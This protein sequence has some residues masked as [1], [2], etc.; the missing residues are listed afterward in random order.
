MPTPLDELPEWASHLFDDALDQ[1]RAR[2]RREKEIDDGSSLAA[3]DAALPGASG[4][5]WVALCSGVNH[6]TALRSLWLTTKRLH[7]FADPTLLRAALLAA[8][9]AV[10]YLDASAGVDRRERL[11]RLAL[12]KLA[13]AHDRLTAAKLT[14]DWAIASGDDAADELRYRDAVQTEYD[15]AAGV[16]KA[17]GATRAQRGGPL[18]ANL[19]VKV[20]AEATAS[21]YPP[22]MRQAVSIAYRLAWQMG[23][24]DAHS[25]LWQVLA[26]LAQTN[27]P[28]R[29]PI[30][31]DL[32][33]SLNI[34]FAAA[35]VLNHGWWLWQLRSRN[36]AALLARDVEPPPLIAGALRHV[37]SP[38]RSASSALGLVR[39]VGGERGEQG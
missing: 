12:G 7:V 18:P 9:T 21:K 6:L 16:A 1:W 34:L 24:A 22:S 32:G 13:D 25:R 26:R 28:S 35:D 31:P 36:H 15:N 20:A 10:Y 29:A 11:R 33:Q 4:F 17:H 5:T 2:A 3:E 14:V 27:D 38:E 8:S 37:Q 19:C 30:E 39:H 23:S